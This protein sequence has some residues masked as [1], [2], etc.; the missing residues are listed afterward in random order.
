[1]TY[2]KVS[3]AAT[4]YDLTSSSEATTAPRDKWP[5]GSS[6]PRKPHSMD[7]VTTRAGECVS[8]KMPQ[9]TAD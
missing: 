7:I 2:L 9:A 4:G 5:D 3:R 6:V 8:R 1:M